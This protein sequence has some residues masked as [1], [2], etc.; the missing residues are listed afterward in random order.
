MA[1]FNIEVFLND[2]NNLSTEVSFIKFTQLELN[3]AYQIIKFRTHVGK[4]GRSIHVYLEAGIV[5]LPKRYQEMITDEQVE[6]LN[7]GGKYFELYVRKLKVF[8]SGIATPLLEI[9]LTTTN[10]IN[11]N[12]SATTSSV[13][14]LH[15]K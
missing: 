9:K 13:S 3:R 6:V 8:P 7:K 1:S 12:N 14:A 10:D 15:Q 4:F 5:V 2:I 11:S